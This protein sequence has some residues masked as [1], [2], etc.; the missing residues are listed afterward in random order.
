M[1]ELADIYE[2]VENKDRVGFGLDTQHMWASGYN[3]QTDLEK[4]VKEIDSVFGFDKVWSVHLNDSMTDFASRKDRH[5]NIGEGKIG[6]EALEAF[7]NHPQLVNIPFI[8]ET[9]A[10][11]S[12]E[13]AAAEVNRVRELF[14]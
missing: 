6:R 11:K 12:M 14:K 4:I 10:L 13:T 8:L 5:A 7:V 1:Q 9:P 3:F 2:Q